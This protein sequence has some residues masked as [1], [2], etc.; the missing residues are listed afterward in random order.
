MSCCASRK[1]IKS[2]D[3][4]RPEREEEEEKTDVRRRSVNHFNGYQEDPMESDEDQDPDGTKVLCQLCVHKF[5]QL[6]V[7]I[8][9]PCKHQICGTCLSKGSRNVNRNHCPYPECKFKL[10]IIEV[11]KFWTQKLSSN[12]DYN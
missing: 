1:Q 11:N 8:N 2:D 7:F 5:D 6:D 4:P 3:P 10:N 9:N 12:T